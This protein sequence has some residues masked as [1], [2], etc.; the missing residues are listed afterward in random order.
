MEKIAKPGAC[1]LVGLNGTQLAQP[2]NPMSP[3][4]PL[5]CFALRQQ[6]AYWTVEHE[7]DEYKMAGVRCPKCAERGQEVWVIPGKNCHVCGN[8][9]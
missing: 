5:R 8:P 6:R 1:D 2:V 9:C 4:R 3:V 7:A